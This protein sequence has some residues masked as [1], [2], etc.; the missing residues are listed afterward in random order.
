MAPRRRPPGA[1]DELPSI[2]RAEDVDVVPGRQDEAAAHGA[3]GLS[4]VEERRRRIVVHR[5][6]AGRGRPA[7]SSSS[8]ARRAHPVEDGI[9][10]G[11]AGP[12]ERLRRRVP[13][14]VG[15]AEAVAGDQLAEEGVEPAAGDARLEVRA[16]GTRLE[17]H[18][19]VDGEELALDQQRQALVARLGL[20]QAGEGETRRRPGAGLAAQAGG[21]ERGARR[22]PGRRRTP[23]P[24][25]RG[26][27]G[28]ARCDRRP[29]R[30]GRRRRCRSA[31][32]DRSP[33]SAPAGP[34][35]GRARG[36]AMLKVRAMTYGR[37]NDATCA[38]GDSLTNSNASGATS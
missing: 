25:R 14:H 38:F 16:C 15:E 28:S 26:P 32:A 11:V 21:V 23:A 9:G 17:P 31:A 24:R 20:D 2:D 35:G 19:D 8:R 7:A 18:V 5:R 30:R 4:P 1:I 27:S 6:A 37:R 36:C 10:A 34:R 22:R 3:A 33:G 12:D 29:A 13:Q